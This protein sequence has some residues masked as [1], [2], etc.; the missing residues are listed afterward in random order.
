V[1]PGAGAEARAAA[2]PTPGSAADDAAT[3]DALRRRIEETDRAILDL[4]RRRV[5]LARRAGGLKRARGQSI[6]DPERELE[7][8]HLMLEHARRIGLS[9]A[10]IQPIARALIALARAAQEDEEQS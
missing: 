2:A 5:E 4:T 10:R 7:V 6:I 3:L 1:I 8:E 9:G